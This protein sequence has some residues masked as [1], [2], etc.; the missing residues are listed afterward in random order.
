M[1]Q[2]VPKH[3]RRPVRVAATIPNH[4]HTKLQM[5][6]NEQGRSL[7][8]LIAYILENYCYPDQTDCHS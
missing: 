2:A 4:V 7:S 3:L 6:S 5:Y 1:I 8:N